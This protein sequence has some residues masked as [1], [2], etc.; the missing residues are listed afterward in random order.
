MNSSR[1]SVKM[2]WDSGGMNQR[3]DRTL[4]LYPPMPYSHE[5]NHIVTIGAVNTILF[6]GTKF[7]VTHWRSF[8]QIQRSWRCQDRRLC[9]IH[10]LTLFIRWN[11]LARKYHDGGDNGGGMIELADEGF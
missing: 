4:F 10:F 9:G 7:A 11:N 6:I 5:S 3:H 8:I 1:F 2:S